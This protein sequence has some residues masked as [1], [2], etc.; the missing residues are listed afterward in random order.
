MRHTDAP[1]QAQVAQ[2]VEQGTE[3]PRVGG[4]IPPLGT[5]SLPASGW[6]FIGGNRFSIASP[7]D[8]SP[9]S[10]RGPRDEGASTG[11]GR[12]SAHDRD[13]F[14]TR[15]S[16]ARISRSVVTRKRAIGPIMTFCQLALPPPPML[17][18][19]LDRREGCGAD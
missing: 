7:R 19:C 18:H 12:S 15:R 6:I 2:S 10:R 4:S 16:T 9:V 17:P 5:N 1:R 3:N 13:S 11:R 14:Q 8:H